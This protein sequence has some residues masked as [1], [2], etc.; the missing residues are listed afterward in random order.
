MAVN[1]VEKSAQKLNAYLRSHGKKQGKAWRLRVRSL[2]AQTFEA[3]N[4]KPLNGALC[5]ELAGKIER[6]IAALEGG[7]PVETDDVV[8]EPLPSEAR[9]AGQEKEEAARIGAANSAAAERIETGRGAE[10]PA[11]SRDSDAG[12]TRIERENTSDDRQIQG[13]ESAPAQAD[14]VAGD[15]SP[16]KEKNNPDEIGLFD[17]IH[18]QIRC[19]FKLNACIRPPYIGKFVRYADKYGEVV[20]A[21]VDR[22]I[23]VLSKNEDE[24]AAKLEAEVGYDEDL[25]PDMPERG[26]VLHPRKKKKR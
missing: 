9:N 12:E 3:L 26:L 20:Q 24:F 2:L 16:A 21:R 14:S 10:A 13:E 7:E 19:F 17:L 1:S 25:L 6:E 8:S 15:T 18:I 22:F 23:K 4:A 5:L 11:P